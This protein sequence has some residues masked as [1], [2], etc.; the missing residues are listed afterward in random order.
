MNFK[1][2]AKTGTGMGSYSI[3]R[4]I[5]SPSRVTSAKHTSPAFRI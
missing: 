5:P 1:K 4:G 2:K 3:L